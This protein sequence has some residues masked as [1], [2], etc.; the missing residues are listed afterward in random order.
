MTR[1][2]SFALVA[3]AAVIAFLTM[4]AVLGTGTDKKGSPET[5]FLQGKV[6]SGKKQ[7]EA[8]VWVIAETADLPT[9]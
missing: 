5:G 4:G 7:A 9:P 6:T 3:A 8:G 2:R 1:K